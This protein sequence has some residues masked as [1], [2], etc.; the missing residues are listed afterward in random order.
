MK[1]NRMH[2]TV[3]TD[4]VADNRAVVDNI[5]ALY[6]MF[7]S[8]NTTVTRDQALICL[9]RHYQRLSTAEWVATDCSLYRERWWLA[10]AD[11]TATQSV[12]LHCL[13]SPVGLVAAVVAT[14]RSA[15]LLITSSRPN[16][17][18]PDIHPTPPM[19]WLI[20]TKRVSSEKRH[21]MT[22]SVGECVKPL[23]W[24]WMILYGQHLIMHRTIGLTH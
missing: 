21:G 6:K 2:R 23:Q 16:H 15:I 1:L 19:P 17:T 3:R 22:C 14:P 11:R 18:I 10:L 9:P 20:D 7:G 13:S 24:L 8:I 4:S 12:A 5:W